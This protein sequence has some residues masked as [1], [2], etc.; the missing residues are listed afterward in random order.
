MIGM[1]EARH[2]ILCNLEMQKQLQKCAPNILPDVVPHDNGVFV[3]EFL[4]FWNACFIFPTLEI[5]TNFNK[6][7]SI[8]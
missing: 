5:A 7:R 8:Q 1:V 6:I 4:L 3:E 2:D